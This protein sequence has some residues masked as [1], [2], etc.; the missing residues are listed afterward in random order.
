MQEI[1]FLYCKYNKKFHVLIKI[2]ALTP[3]PNQQ[4]STDVINWPGVELSASGGTVVTPRPPVSIAPTQRPPAPAQPRPPP[5]PPA[6][7]SGTATTTR[8]PP[9]A[10]TACRPS[11][12]TVRGKAAC[13][14]ELIFQDHFDTLDSNKW[15][16][17]V[18]I[19][20][21]PVSTIDFIFLGF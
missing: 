19:A 21:T 4:A 8:R 1:L 16:H 14:G 11:S 15:S 20:D 18:H 5:R 2:S 3:L 13:K 9:A 12:T 6:G 17:A 7:I 10:N